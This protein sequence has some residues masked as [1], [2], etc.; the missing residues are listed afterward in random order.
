MEP[1]IEQLSFDVDDDSVSAIFQYDYRHDGEQ[2]PPG[3]RIRKNLRAKSKTCVE[4]EEALKPTRSIQ[5]RSKRSISMTCSRSCGLGLMNGSKSMKFDH[6]NSAL[7]VHVLEALVKE[8]SAVVNVCLE[9]LEDEEEGMSNAVARHFHD[10]G[11]EFN[12]TVSV[13]GSLQ[14][15]ELEDH[16]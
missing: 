5:A 8:Y 15:T 13:V 9:G 1:D 10:I 16:N 12:H 7:D 4:Y 11:Q 6:I 3:K 2:N 14:E